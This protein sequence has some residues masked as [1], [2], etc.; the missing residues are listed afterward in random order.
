MSPERLKDMAHK[1]NSDCWSIGMIVL[2]CALGH[3]PFSD[4]PANP[5]EPVAQLSVFSM[6]Q[7][8]SSAD[9]NVALQRVKYSDLFNE[10]CLA[11]LTR[12]PELRPSSSDLAKHPW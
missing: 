11:C 10:F 9:P 6:M 7:R 12:D 8:I 4:P 5:G 3:Y 2:E 1:M